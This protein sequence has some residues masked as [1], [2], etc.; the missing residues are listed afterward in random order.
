MSDTAELIIAGGGIAGLAT[1]IALRQR[2]IEAQVLEQAPEIREIGAGLLLAPNACKVLEKLGALGFLREGR[3]VEVPR[4]ELRNWR[5][6][7]LS[8]LSVPRDGELALSTRWS[9]LQLALLSCLPLDFV[10]LG[11]QVKAVRLLPDGVLLSPSDG[12]EMKAR[13]VIIADGAHSAARNSLWLGSEP[14][15]CGYVG[16]RGIVDHVPRGWEAGRVSESWGQGRRFGIAPVGGGRTYWYATA[17]VPAAQC[18]ARVSIAQLRRDFAGWHA[19]VAEILEAM[20]DEDL[21]QHPIADRRPLPHW[22]LEEKAVLI[23]DAAH[24]LT[25]N[26]GQGASM[27]LEDAWELAGLWG[28]RDAMTC[29]EKRRRWRVMRLWA[30]SGSLGKLIQWEGATACGFRDLQLRATPDALS[31]AMMRSILRY[32]PAAAG[33]P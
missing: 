9:D 18:H 27:A 3:A 7:L 2:G 4:W 29:Y 13:Q 26:L 33:L 15:Y 8:A 14:H 31:T 16:W 17:N 19:P 32:E 25:P 10:Q 28:R 30:M 12:R 5:G 22:Q 6:K 23:G 24:P 11:C 20:R 21:L 1:A